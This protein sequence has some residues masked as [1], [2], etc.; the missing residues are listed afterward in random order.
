MQYVD[1]P[2]IKTL[3]GISGLLFRQFPELRSKLWNWW[4]PPYYVGMACVCTNDSEVHRRTGKITA[5]R[6]PS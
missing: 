3:K 5:I 4:S 6:P 2:T 1:S